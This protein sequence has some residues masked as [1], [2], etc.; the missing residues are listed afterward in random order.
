MLTVN[1]YT[2]EVSNSD[3]PLTDLDLSTVDVLVIINSIGTPFSSPNDRPMS[4]SDK[5]KIQNFAAS[6][7]GFFFTGDWPKAELPKYNDISGIFGVTMDLQYIDYIVSGRP[8][9]TYYVPY[10]Y[11]Y[12]FDY[13]NYYSQRSFSKTV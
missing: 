7:K 4:P 9:V 13:I 12:V 6:G 1:G 5:T 2:V 10:W 11:A 8:P 3:I